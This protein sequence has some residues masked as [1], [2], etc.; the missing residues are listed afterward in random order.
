[1][2]KSSYGL[3]DA[4]RRWWQVVDDKAV[5]GY[6]LVP[7]RADRCTYILYGDQKSSN[8]L[9]KKNPQE[10]LILEDALELLMNAS[11]RNGSQGRK[12]EGFIC[13]HVDD[14]YMA[15]SPEFENLVLSR[16]RKDFNV[17]SEDTKNILFV[18]QRITW[19]QHEKHGYFISYDQKFAVDQLGRNKG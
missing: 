3:N 10:E 9:T 7:T 15:G 5:L 4:P 11:V 17:A 6:G 19:K 2:T 1:M 16:I 18:G 14:L 8:A 13:L 12:P